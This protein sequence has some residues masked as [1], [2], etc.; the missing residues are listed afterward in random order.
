MEDKK[1]KKYNPYWK[2]NKNKSKKPAGEEIKTPDNE[3]IKESK[4]E[5]SNKSKKKTVAEL[6]EVVHNEEVK[7]EDIEVTEEVP[8]AYDPTKTVT[9]VGVRYKDGGKT[10]YFDPVDLELSIDEAVIVDTSRGMEFGFISV[11][12]KVVRM[13]ELVADLKCVIRKATDED[14]EKYAKNKQLEEK[15][16]KLW[17]SRVAAFGLVMQLVDVEY[18]FDNSKLIFFY[19]ADGR[20][21]FREL[22]KDLAGLFHTRIE[23]RQIGVRD[24]AKLLGGLGICGRPFCCKEFLKEFAQVSIKMAKEQ[25]LSLTSSKISG[26]CGRLMCCLSYEQKVYE[27]EY[28]T[29]PKVDSLVETPQGQGVICES[30][31]L[32][33]KIKV[34]LMNADR[35]Q[36]AK[37][38]TADQIK[39]IGMVRKKE[40]EED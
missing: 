35:A 29:F 15:A 34:K 38:F 8:E 17:A 26:N 11:P 24:E 27:M 9:V 16:K 18:T 32:T 22:V 31:F 5:E 19:T 39:V 23:L 4:P 2:K 28:A 13:S 25:N 6:Y 40:T 12:N 37:T 1:K 3:E 14:K 30:N 33:G 20:V 10:Y 21:D 36:P 7:S